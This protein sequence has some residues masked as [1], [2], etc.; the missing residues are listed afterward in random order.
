MVS[1]DVIVQG[2]SLTGMPQSNPV[3]LRFSYAYE[4]Q[5]FGSRLS[6]LF[7]VKP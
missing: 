5:G 1:H 7:G 6:R 2:V 4:I 3:L